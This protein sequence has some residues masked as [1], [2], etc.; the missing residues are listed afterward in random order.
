MTDHPNL[1]PA[2]PCTN[3]RHTG[4]IRDQFGCNGP[5]PAEQAAPT[6]TEKDTLTGDS[7]PATPR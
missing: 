6:S 5:D 1:P 2:K 4:A 7:T 3:P